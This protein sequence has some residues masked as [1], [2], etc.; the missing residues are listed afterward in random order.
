MQTGQLDMNACIFVYRYFI[1]ITFKYQRS[2]KIFYRNLVTNRRQELF[3]L[4]VFA[5]NVSSLIKI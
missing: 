1:Y 3:V 2:K 4:L 5:K